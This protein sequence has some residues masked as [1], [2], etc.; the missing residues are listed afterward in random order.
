MGNSSYLRF[1][2]DGTEA[3]R[4]LKRLKKV[5]HWYSYYSQI[6]RNKQEDSPFLNCLASSK[7]SKG[8]LKALRGVNCWRNSELLHMH[9][10]TSSRPDSYFA[11]AGNLCSLPAPLA[12]SKDNAVQ[13]IK[14]ES[15]K[16]KLFHQMEGW[17]R[18][19][20]EIKRQVEEDILVERE[21]QR[22]NKRQY[23]FVAKTARRSRILRNLRS[24]LLSS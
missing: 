12:D 10:Q 8:T 16:R 2:R 21:V 18:I 3:K 6:I 20:L 17:I 4:L 24:F 15:F 19:Q 11:G 22:A 1:I 5:C 13:S 9:Y 7:Y 23:L 14:K